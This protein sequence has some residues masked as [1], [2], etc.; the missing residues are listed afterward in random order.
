[1]ARQVL[2]RS[3]ASGASSTRSPWRA[4]AKSFSMVRDEPSRLMGIGASPGMMAPDVWPD[5]W[6]NCTPVAYAGHLPDVMKE[7]GNSRLDRCRWGDF[8]ML[9]GLMGAIAVQTGLYLGAR[10]SGL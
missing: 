7:S 6:R 5:R 8:G 2:I 1:M 3:T 9:L 4:T 10:L